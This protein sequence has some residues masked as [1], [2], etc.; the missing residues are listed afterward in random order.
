M[1]GERKTGLIYGGNSSGCHWKLRTCKIDT[2]Y[3]DVVIDYG[4][5]SQYDLEDF[6]GIAI[7]TAFQII[8]K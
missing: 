3:I 4:G 2:C 6:L 8:I 1:S 7:R 5:V